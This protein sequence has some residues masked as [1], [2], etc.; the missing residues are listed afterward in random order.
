M[1]KTCG[2]C[3][4]KNRLTSSYCVQCGKLLSGMYEKD[5]VRKDS[6]V[7]KKE[8]NKVISECNSKDVQIRA[9]KDENNRLRQNQHTA[10]I[11]SKIV[12]NEEYNGLLSD[13]KMLQSYKSNGFAPWG[14]RLI[15]DAE[16]NRL[17]RSWYKKLDDGF[18]SW[19]DENWGFA[20]VA[21]FVILAMSFGVVKFVGDRKALPSTEIEIVKDSKTYKY[22]IFNNRNQSLVAPYDFDS[23]SYRKGRDYQGVYRNYYY[24]YKDGKV[25]F[26]DST[27]KVTINC[28]LDR[29]WGPY[30]GLIIMQKDEKKGLLDTYGHQILPCE[31]QNIIWEKIPTGY[32][33]IPVGNIIPVRKS[34]SEGWELHDRSG[35]LIRGQ[36]YKYVAQ[37]GDSNL[38]MVRLSGQPLWGLIDVDGNEILPC[39][40]FHISTFENERGWVQEHYKEAWELITSKGN[41]IKTFPQNYTPSAFREGL[42]VVTDENNKIGYC[43]VS[44]RLVIPIEFEIIVKTDPDFYN[45][46]AKVSYNG[47][48]GYIDKTGKFTPESANK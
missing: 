31:Y 5:V 25:G 8:F 44:G 28:D 17:N 1:E 10:P 35:R 15:T 32:S 40:Y 13:R 12:T 24:L 18:E 11:G 9:L 2:N 34:S 20:L 29:T 43:D 4:H 36:K 45:G 21:F 41:H 22:G 26:A 30:N 37:T 39:K 14:K 33:S 48:P 46:K 19:M 23:I 38:I 47:K 6:Y 42:A 7:E 3:G 27:G 16:Y